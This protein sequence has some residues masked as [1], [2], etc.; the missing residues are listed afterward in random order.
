MEVRNVMPQTPLTPPKIILPGG[1]GVF[2]PKPEVMCSTMNAVPTTSGLLN[3][4]KLPLAMHIHPYKDLSIQ[5][6]P[7]IHPT[8]IVRCRVCRAYINPF[9]MF[10]DSRHWRC[11]LCFR[12]NTLPEEFDYN[13][14]TG[15]HGDRSQRMEIKRS[16]VE[17]IAPSE[18]ML[19]PPQPC[20]YLFLIDV[21]YTAVQSGVLA[22]ACRCLLDCLGRLPGDARTMVGFVTYDSSLHFYNLSVSSTVHVQE[23]LPEQV[24]YVSIHYY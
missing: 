4:M 23:L 11:N 13:P 7:V 9:V 8:T 22:V 1:L 3:K 2:N 6:C 15:K 19:R 18:Y 17:Y 12:P 24:L 16:S 14:Q 10:I 5:E 20:V 21:S